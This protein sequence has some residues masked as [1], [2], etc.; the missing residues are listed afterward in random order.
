MKTGEPGSFASACS[1]LF[2]GSS[3]TSKLYLPQAF[4]HCL[5]VHFQLYV[6][7]VWNALLFNP[8]P[9]NTWWYPLPEICGLIGKAWARLF[10]VDIT[11]LHLH[12]LTLI[13]WSY[14]WIVPLWFSI[15][16][17]DI[18][19]GRLFFHYSLYIYI[20]LVWFIQ[21]TKGAFWLSICAFSL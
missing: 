11:T 15:C 12:D 3:G 17:L 19:K 5:W 16:T 6:C 20:Y 13:Y 9:E 21:V 14:L 1:I 18:R 2:E 10:F 8:V 4:L 7:E